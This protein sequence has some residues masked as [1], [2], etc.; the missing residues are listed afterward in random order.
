MHQLHL[1]ISLLLAIFCF[2]TAISSL[3]VQGHCTAVNIPAG[4]V[5]AP[6]ATKGKLR[7]SGRLGAADKRDIMDISTLD[8]RGYGIC[9]YCQSEAH[10]P[11]TIA[12]NLASTVFYLPKGIYSVKWLAGYDTAPP[13][14]IPLY[15]E[16]FREAGRAYSDSFVAHIWQYGGTFVNNDP[17]SGMYVVLRQ[18]GSNWGNPTAEVWMQAQ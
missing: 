13:G 12:L 9:Y 2:F 10:N 18:I 15:I 11:R 5:A 16:I 6:T 4:C 14:N 17:S 3:C 8:S 1:F 7:R